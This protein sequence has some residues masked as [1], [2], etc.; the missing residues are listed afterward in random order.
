MLFFFSSTCCTCEP[1]QLFLLFSYLK[2]VIRSAL[3]SAFWCQPS[4]WR[5]FN[6]LCFYAHDLGYC[7][8]CSWDTICRPQARLMLR[9]CLRNALAF[10][11]LSLVGFFSQSGKRFK[12][13][14][15]T[16]QT[17]LL[18]KSYFVSASLP[19]WPL[20]TLC[21]PLTWLVGVI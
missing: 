8:L 18:N 21:Q 2:Y 6:E 4:T 15:Y 5:C 1:C 19:F 16:F 14:V 17:L 3:V 11:V 12:L 20:R 13:V 10:S 7:S 9:Y